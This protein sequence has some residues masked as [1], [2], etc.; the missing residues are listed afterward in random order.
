MRQTIVLPLSGK[1]RE[2]ADKMTDSLRLKLRRQV[3]R[4]GP[5]ARMKVLSWIEVEEVWQG[6]PPG[7]A[8]PVEKMATFL[9]RSGAHVAI[10][11]EL[12][13]AGQRF[14]LRVRGVDLT[15]EAGSTFID[16]KFLAQGERSLGM[17]ADQVVE[18]I[19]GE[20]VKKPREQGEVPEPAT[21]GPAV[22]VNAG[23]EKGSAEHPTG[24][25]RT[26]GL[27]TF[28]KPDPD[29]IRGRVLM[30]D[31]RMEQSQA[32]AWWA[33]WRAGASPADAPQPILAKPPFYSSVGGLHGAHYYSDWHEVK[34]GMRYRMIAEMKG[35][36]SGM[37]FPKVFV[38]GYAEVP[39][40]RRED[41]PQRRE[42]WR[43]YMSCRNPEGTWKRYTVTFTIPAEGIQ[44]TDGPSL[45]VKWLRVI[46][47]AYWPPGRFYWDNVRVVE[48]PVTAEQP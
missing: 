14:A 11:G 21:L 24:W 47:Y 45:K 39:P 25:D 40:S 15:A 8:T 44:L 7:A 10:W 9:R 48:E 27:T 18:A 35:R 33:K 26:D 12:I 6:D 19:T 2:L 41:K 34:P 36:S 28:T 13:R 3:R 29:G 42:I 22:T 17:L 37:F 38:K 43:T 30:M 23:F 1:D 4:I 46:P 31:T 16:R 32:D 20:A 5:E